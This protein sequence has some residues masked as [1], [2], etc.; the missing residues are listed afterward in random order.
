[1]ATNTPY[2][3]RCVRYHPNGRIKTSGYYYNGK[4][5]GEY[6]RWYDTGQLMM[7]AYHKE[8]RLDG[9]QTNFNPDGSVD[10]Y[11]YFNNGAY[12]GRYKDIYQVPGYDNVGL[13]DQYSIAIPMKRDEVAECENALD[14]MSI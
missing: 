7:L 12:I 2:Q 11:Q 8:G 6:M 10:S 5:E 13:F 9:L 4:L 3:G 14:S 1:M